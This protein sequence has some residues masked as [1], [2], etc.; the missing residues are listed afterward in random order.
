MRV[1]HTHEEL[2]C[3]PDTDSLDGRIQDMEEER[4]ISVRC[5]A[6]VGLQRLFLRARAD[7]TPVPLSIGPH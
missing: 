1:T 3:A 5:D 6:E 4:T 2:K 7:T